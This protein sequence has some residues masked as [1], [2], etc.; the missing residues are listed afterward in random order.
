[1]TTH[2][3]NAYADYRDTIIDTYLDAYKKADHVCDIL[4]DKD[5]LAA[6]DADQNAILECVAF[7]ADQAG[8]DM[9]YYIDI[10]LH[11]YSPAFDVDTDAGIFKCALTASVI[12]DIL[13]DAVDQKLYDDA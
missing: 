11:A 7:F 10:A 2:H 12:N 8:R 6:W 3:T 5:L 13:T 9:A 4:D 1:M